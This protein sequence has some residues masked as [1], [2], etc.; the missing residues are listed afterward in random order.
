[1]QEIQN[2]PEHP[3]DAHGRNPSL[4]MAMVP[5]GST[6]SGWTANL[7]HSDMDLS[8]PRGSD[9]W[10][11]KNPDRCPGISR[12]GYLTALPIPNLRTCTR[13]Q[14]RDYFD[15]GWTI[16]EAL[17]ASLNTEEAFYRPPY[18]DLRH[19]MVFYY[20]HPAVL[21]VNKLRVAGL[22]HSPV[23]EYIESLFETGV[24][25]MSWD[26]MAKNHIRWPSIDQLIAYRRQVYELVASVIESHEGIADGHRPITMNDPLWALFMGF[27]HERIHIETSSVL[28]RELPLHLVKR[29]QWLPPLHP[30]A[31]EASRSAPRAGDDYP[32]NPF[33]P[34][35]GGTV[36]LGKPVDFPTFGWDNEYGE[37][38]QKV[39]AFEVSRN[40]ISNGEFW[41]FVSSGG[42]Q[43]RRYWSD[44]G[45]RWRTFRNVKWPT[46]WTPCGPAG[47]HEYSLRTCFETVAMPWSWP[48]VVNYHEARAYALWRQEMDSS[49]DGE[50]PADIV[51]ELPSEAQHQRLRQLC[52]QTDDTVAETANLNFRWGSESPVGQG[53]APVSDLF[54]NVWQWLEDHFNPLPGFRIHRYYDDFSTPCYDGE[55]QMIMG[56]SFISIGDEATSHARF[57]FRPHFF[58]HSGFRLARRKASAASG[59]VLLNDDKDSSGSASGSVASELL[60]H[61]FAAEALSPLEKVSGQLACY[62]QTVADWL[63]AYIDE[64]GT[65]T[66]SALEVGGSVGGLAYILAGRFQKVISVDLR[67]HLVDAAQKLRETGRVEVCVPEEGALTRDYL[68]DLDAERLNRIDF[69][70]CDPS[71]L[72]ADYVGFDAVVLSDVI[73]RLPSP[74]ALLSRMY[75]PRGL[76][77][78]RGLLL[79]LSAF[80]WSE[81]VTPK[82]LWLGGYVDESGSPVSSEDSLR[83]AL[84]PEFQLLQKRDLPMVIRHD[85]R[86]FEIRML[87]GLLFKRSS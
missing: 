50:I 51:Y 9:W 81:R 70:R 53:D 84:A 52:G 76:V 36:T 44:T 69:R 67:G 3:R 12:E 8:C 77:A 28:M 19:P 23:D 64:A 87:T 62:Q 4:G 79:V 6:D 38:F 24:D 31:S 25:E 20:A 16:T 39:D 34:V 22:V 33:V 48:C 86:R 32:V 30:S 85:N 78:P 35:S 45:W 72:P 15:N 56:G 21:Y 60:S 29:S 43:E 27:E 80:D 11:G 37:R 47:S 14:V 42:Y 54:G 61:Y 75:G 7:G 55:H 82:E 46:F 74:S 10:T 41:A 65:G 49:V 58:Q 71:S 1:M 5:A 26:D 17:F 63:T 2:K 66:G 73:T 40:L 18:H 13:Q 83:S 57:H 59:V 68:R